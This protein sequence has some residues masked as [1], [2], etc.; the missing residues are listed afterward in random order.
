MPGLILSA[1]RKKGDITYL[2]IERDLEDNSYNSLSH[3]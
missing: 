2:I 1:V 3:K